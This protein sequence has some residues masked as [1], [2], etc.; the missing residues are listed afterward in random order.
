MPAVSRAGNRLAYCQVGWRNNL[1]IWRLNFSASGKPLGAPVKIISSSQGQ[2]AP[3]ISPDGRHIVF[4]SGRSGNMEIWM[5]DSNGSNLVQLTSFGGPTTGTPRWAPDNRHIVFDSEAGGHPAIYVM[6]IDGPAPE[7]LAPGIPDAH[8]PSWSAD[9]HWIY[10][11]SQEQPGI[12]KFPVGGGPSIQLARENDA[13]LPLESADGTR[14][15]Y[16]VGITRLKSV[17]VNGGD[18]REVPEVDVR[19]NL[20]SESWT[21]APNGIYFLDDRNALTTLQFLNLKTRRVQKIAN[22]PGRLAVWGVSPS[23]SADGRI[24]VVAINDQTIGDIMLAEGF[25]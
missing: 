2:E 19:P 6:S 7:V 11:D 3:R 12:W 21:T 23:L 17:S 16:T 4:E 10:F 1:N 5:A 9:G 8:E 18:E 25:R 20:I 13:N 14:V 22:L 24:L 15:F